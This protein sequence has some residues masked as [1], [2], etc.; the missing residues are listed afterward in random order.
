MKMKIMF[1]SDDDKVLEQD[2]RTIKDLVE[3]QRLYCAPILF[4]ENGYFDPKTEEYSP[5]LMVYDDYL[6]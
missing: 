3:L 6:D 5:A 2:V 1:A 4:D